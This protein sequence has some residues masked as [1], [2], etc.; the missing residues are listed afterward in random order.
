MIIP[1]ILKRRS[2]RSFKSDLVTDEQIEEIIKAGEFAPSAK[3]NHGIKYLVIKNQSTKNKLAEILFQPFV[4]EAPVLIIPYLENGRSVL[5]I[6][7]LSVAT[8]NMMLQAV[9]MGLGTVWKNIGDDLQ[10]N[11]KKIL[12]LDHN[13]IIINLIPV[14]FSKEVPNAYQESDFQKEKIIWK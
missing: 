1:A 9:N 8:E 7:D 5:P 11:V 3:G 2:V 13:I 10:D 14:G 12:N 4:K 6:Q